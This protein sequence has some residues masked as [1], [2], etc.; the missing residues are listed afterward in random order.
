MNEFLFNIEFNLMKK[1]SLRNF[2]KN[3]AIGINVTKKAYLLI[4][5]KKIQMQF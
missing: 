3:N 5:R 1:S 2:N 4:G